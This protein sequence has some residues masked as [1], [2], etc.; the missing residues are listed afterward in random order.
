VT[1]V[2]IG[3]A[4]LVGLLVGAVL[5][6]LGAGGSVLTVPVLM[7]LLGLSATEATGTSLLVV[8]V[9]AAA[10][11]VTHARMGR[12]EWRA[13]LGFLVAGVPG[14]ALGGRAAVLLSDLVLTVVLI[15]VLAA[16]GVWMWFRRPVER[17]AA[18]APWS[19]VVPVGLAVG[20]FTGLL[21]VGG[22]FVVVPA[23]VALMA[24]P[25]SLAVGT[26]QLVLLANAAAGLIGR[27]GSGAVQVVVG[28]VF[29]GAGA[30]GSAIAS[31]KAGH[32]PERVLTR[33]FAVLVSAVS[34]TLLVDLLV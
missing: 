3:L 11:L 17:P 31:R 29:A 20:L 25:M 1:G 26:S 14:A 23:L 7:L 28:L 13:G 24:L 18:P 6:L 32:I 15:A 4:L 19:R 30:A 34:L 10:G 27:I 5:G 2:E 21:G 22:G 16:T 33:A 8:V 12:V 9:V